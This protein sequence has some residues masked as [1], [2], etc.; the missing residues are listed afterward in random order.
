MS[1]MTPWGEADHAT[2]LAEGI[3]EYQT[4][5]HGGI[6]LSKKRRDQI[7]VTGVKTFLKTLEWFEEDCDAAVAIW[8]FRDEIKAYGNVPL[9][10]VYLD[11]CQD[12]IRMYHK[13]CSNVLLSSPAV[14]ASEVTA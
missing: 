10:P 1:K 12:T 2:V 7:S 5:S 13:E 6:W 3:I 8:Y 11:A 9:T 14:L 4:P